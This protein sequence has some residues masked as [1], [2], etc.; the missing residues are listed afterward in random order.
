L[1]KQI[2]VSRRALTARIKRALAAQGLA[3]RT[4]RSGGRITLMLVR[5]DH[6]VEHGDHLTLDKLVTD[7]KVLKPWERA[8]R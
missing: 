3:L 4:D 1:P 6:I 8:G 7:L 5:D 2:T